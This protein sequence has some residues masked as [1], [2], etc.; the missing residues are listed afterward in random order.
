MICC[1]DQ[2]DELQVVLVAL[3]KGKKKKTKK[4]RDEQRRLLTESITVDHR[5]PWFTT[6]HDTGVSSITVGYLV[7]RYVRISDSPK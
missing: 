5:P 2:D 3:R 4:E 7:K 1:T 6:G